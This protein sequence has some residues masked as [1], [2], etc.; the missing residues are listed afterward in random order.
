M[1]GAGNLS[2]TDTLGNTVVF[3]VVAGQTIAASITRVNATSTT[4]T[5]LVGYLA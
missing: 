2:L 3:A 5:G 1:G 4:A